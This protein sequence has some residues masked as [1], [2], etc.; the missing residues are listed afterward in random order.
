MQQELVRNKSKEKAVK[1]A[2]YMSKKLWHQAQEDHHKIQANI[3]KME[4]VLD[5]LRAETSEKVPTIDTSKGAGGND[6]AGDPLATTG[7]EG[8]KEAAQRNHR[9]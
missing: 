2:S 5:N 9:T 4:L 8:S 7:C 3:I 1:E 6:C